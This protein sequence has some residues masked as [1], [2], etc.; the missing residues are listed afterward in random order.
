MSARPAVSDVPDPR[1]IAFASRRRDPASKREAVLLTAVQ[2]FLERSYSRTSLNDVAERLHITKP[3]LY[4]YFRNK[5]DILLECYRIGTGLIGRK[6][7]AIEA[8][9]G[10]GLQKVEAFI[11]AYAEVMTV[12]FGRCVMHLD[13]G[14]LSAEAVAEVRRYKRRIDRKLRA[15]IEAGMA[16]GSIAGCH[17]KLAAFAIAGALNWMC[18]WYRPDG[19]LSAP[20]IARQFAVTLTQ[21]LAPRDARPQPKKKRAAAG[22]KSRVREEKK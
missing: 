4:H 3:A 10:T 15:F 9:G 22:P 12:N 19:E 14:D 17:P 20:A 5:E 21:G 8:A 18:M 6:I 2:M 13:E 7:A 16:D 11:S 1:L